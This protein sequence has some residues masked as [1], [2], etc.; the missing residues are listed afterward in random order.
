MDKNISDQIVNSPD[1][2]QTRADNYPMSRA[3]QIKLL[4]ARRA[5]LIQQANGLRDQR[6]GVL[7]EVGEIEKALASMGINL[8]K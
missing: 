4:L 2:N 7:S 1:G 3:D 8:K 6:Q 5:G